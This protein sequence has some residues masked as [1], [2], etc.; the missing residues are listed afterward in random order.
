MPP[1]SQTH[2]HMQQSS[3]PQMGASVLREC[4]NIIHA[5]YVH[6]KLVEDEMLQQLMNDIRL[7]S[8]LA[9]VVTETSSL[10]C[11]DAPP[12]AS[13]DFDRILFLRMSLFYSCSITLKVFSEMLA[14]PIAEVNIH[15]VA[16]ELVRDV[17]NRS[18]QIPKTVGLRE[19]KEQAK[20]LGYSADKA[21]GC[22]KHGDLL[23]EQIFSSWEDMRL[24]EDLYTTCK[25]YI[26]DL[27]VLD[28]CHT[29]E[30]NMSKNAT[31]NK[32][33]NCKT[34]L[35]SPHNLDNRTCVLNYCKRT[36]L[37]DPVGAS[38][39]D[40]LLAKTYFAFGIHY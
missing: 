4:T 17:L 10:W 6:R 26:T 20:Y 33:V 1:L 29:V 21:D 32:S 35:R 31:T 15:T 40:H 7:D 19:F 18:G 13:S 28:P 14:V 16:M 3:L 34:S 27:E 30:S 25:R 9:S 39:V 12:A 22:R 37:E 8:G 2:T 24:L 36:P 38:H 11:L 5:A 23:M